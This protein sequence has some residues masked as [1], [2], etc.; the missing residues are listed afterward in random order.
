MRDTELL[1]SSNR[2]Y[3]QPSGKMTD[4]MG[5]DGTVGAR[6]HFRGARRVHIGALKEK[7]VGV[8]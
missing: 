6:I 2:K 8:L 7:R 5:T 3:I 4:W 1:L